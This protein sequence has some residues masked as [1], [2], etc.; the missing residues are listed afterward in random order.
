MAVATG[1]LG[2]EL[3]KGGDSF[4]GCSVM[5]AC[6]LCP[7]DVRMGYRLAAPCFERSYLGIR[8][9]DG[10]WVGLMAPEGRGIEVLRVS[11]ALSSA[12]DP[13]RV[14]CLVTGRELA[15]SDELLSV[16]CRPLG[17]GNWDRLLVFV[18]LET[19]M[20]ESIVCDTLELLGLLDW[21]K[22]RGAGM[23]TEKGLWMKWVGD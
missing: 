12:L 20:N 8:G 1:G 4:G 3:R 19:G 13:D 15:T 5:I 11:A 14:P 22:R 18:G 17:R 2:L 21:L 10:V 9:E 16:R 23:S 6:K 7:W